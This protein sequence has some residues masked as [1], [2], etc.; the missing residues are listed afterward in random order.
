[1]IKKFAYVLALMASVAGA[2]EAPKTA[3]ATLVAA[4]KTAV[5]EPT[6]TLVFF[7]NPNGRPCQMQN[8]ILE[9]SKK[10]WASS[11]KVKY[12]STDVPAD[13]EAFY[14]Y[15]IRSLPSLIV[16]DR[17]GKEVKRFSPGIQGADVLV[18]FLKALGK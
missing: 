5:A 8:A 11:A 2:A 6:Y 13:R 17:A 10:E 3:K 4:T 1:M 14:Q 9:D 7:M 18:P 12:V 15:G 16:L